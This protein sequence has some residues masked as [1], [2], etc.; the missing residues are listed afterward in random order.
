MAVLV[1]YE[2]CFLS[3]TMDEVEAQQTFDDFFEEVFTELED[4]VCY[5]SVNVV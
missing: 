4:K 5:T 2:Q 1:W 3:V